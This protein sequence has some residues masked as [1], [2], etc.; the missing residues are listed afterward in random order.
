MVYFGSAENKQ[1]I[2]FLL[3]LATS[4][5]LVVLFLSGSLLTNISRG[6]IAYTRVDM[7]AGSIFVF[8][9]SMIISLS[10]WPRVADRLEEREDR[11]KASA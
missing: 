11:N 5:L 4:I 9:I 2:V 3:S 8:V 6:E 1:R 7:A 10:L